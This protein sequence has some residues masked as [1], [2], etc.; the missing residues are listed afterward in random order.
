MKLLVNS[1]NPSS[2]PL[3]KQRFF[4]PENAYRN[5][6]LVLKYHTGSRDM[7]EREAGT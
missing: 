2:N 1:K 6:P 7:P 5:P 3:Q 4:D